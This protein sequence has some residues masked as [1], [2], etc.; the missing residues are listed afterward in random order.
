MAPTLM[1]GIISCVVKHYAM[2]TGSI[3]KDRSCHCKNTYW[4]EANCAQLLA[5]YSCEIG[6]VSSK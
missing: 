3:V 1:E 2:E 6:K 5:E 4:K